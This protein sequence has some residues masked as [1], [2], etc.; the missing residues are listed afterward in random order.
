[1]ISSF[2]K[3]SLPHGPPR[4]ICLLVAMLLFVLDPPP[5]AN[6]ALPSP[7]DLAFLKSRHCRDKPPLVPGSTEKLTNVG[8][9]RLDSASFLFRNLTPT[10]YAE[11]RVESHNLPV[12]L[13]LWRGVM[14]RRSPENYIQWRRIHVNTCEIPYQCVGYGPLP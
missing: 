4:W 1:V 2:Y 6:T 10:T 13:W 11:P 7:L 3:A 5:T 9:S 14:W 8:Q 12:S